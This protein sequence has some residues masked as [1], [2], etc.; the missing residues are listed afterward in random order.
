[1]SNCRA[2]YSDGLTEIVFTGAMSY[3][4]YGVPRSPVFEVVEEIDIDSLH[5]AGEEIDIRTL[6]ISVINIYLSLADSCEFVQDEP[7]EY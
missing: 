4:D 5:L 2:T 6:P 3:T 7:D 1:M